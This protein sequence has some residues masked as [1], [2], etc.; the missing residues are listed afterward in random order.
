M[1]RALLRP[2]SSISSS[3]G[4]RGL[5]SAKKFLLSGLS[6][7]LLLGLSAG[8]V[9]WVFARKSLDPPWDMT[10]KIGGFYNEPR[11]E[12]TAMF[13]GSSHIYASLSPLE[14]W[15]ETG[16]KSYVFATQLQPMWA[17]YTY[18][19]EALKYQSPQLVVVECNM[20]GN[21]TEY[22]DDGV[23]FSFMDDLRFS[24]DKVELAF[25][26]A[27][28][29]ERAPLIWNF[30]KYHGRWS[31]LEDADYHTRKE[32]L[33]DPY[34]GY[35]LLPG[36]YAAPELIPP[37][38]GE[39][40]ELSEKNLYWLGQIMDLCQRRGIELWLIKAPSNTAL[41]EIQRLRME[42]VERVAAARGVPFDDFN[43]CYEEIGLTQADF[44][45]QRHL[46]GGGAVKFTDY[47]ARLMNRRYPQLFAES[48][49]PA[50][51]ADYETYAA[52]L[53]EGA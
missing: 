49:D 33:H 5:S 34:K 38:A 29:G 21:N 1:G 11:G 2:S 9:S 23:N 10:N 35:V 46:N 28:E 42:E 31:E 37:E 47:F 48:E 18:L 53:A 36:Q 40:G 41:E 25:A 19:E 44:Y 22:H 52:A 7:L 17:T 26:S 15:H 14:L 16:V 45:D 4:A 12:F 13:F 39:S 43:Q 20:M 27:P 3:K 6:L 24:L 8:P 30:M 32:D 51:A 50:W